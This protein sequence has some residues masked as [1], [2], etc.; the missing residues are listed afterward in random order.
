VI[1]KRGDARLARIACAHHGV[2]SRAEARACGF[3]D[4]QIDRRAGAGI[5]IRVFPRVYRHASTPE[6]GLVTMAAAVLWAGAGCALSH[7]S[8]ALLW[9]IGTAPLVPEV[10]VPARRGPAHSGVVVHRTNSLDVFDPAAVVTLAGLPV[11]APLR[12]LCD[13]AASVDDAKLHSALS[14][15][16]DRGLVERSALSARRGAGAARLRR[17]VATVPETPGDWLT[18]ADPGPMRERRQNAVPAPARRVRD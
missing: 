5:W 9:R 8:A 7:E 17:M 6:F 11:T 4:A 12:T 13:L 18:N 2:F 16:L 14:A 15:A 3:S 1:S 10:L